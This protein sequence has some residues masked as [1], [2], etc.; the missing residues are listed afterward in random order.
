MMNRWTK[1]CKARVVGPRVYTYIHMYMRPLLG[2]KNV[3]KKAPRG[4]ESLDRS[5]ILGHT[6]VADDRKTLQNVKMPTFSDVQC[7]PAAAIA[8]ISQKTQKC[9]RNQIH[10]GGSLR[11]RLCGLAQMPTVGRYTMP[12]C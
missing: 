12:G 7:F 3:E 10:S 2:V 8:K 1:A 9:F 11:F 5:G 4:L 6:R